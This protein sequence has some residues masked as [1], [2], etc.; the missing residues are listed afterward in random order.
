MEEKTAIPPKRR[1]NPAFVK[2]Q[3]NPYAKP[4]K[5][6]E[7]PKNEN[8]DNSNDDLKLGQLDK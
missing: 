2:G 4:K 3:R 5:A 7:L 1:G 6:K 8:G